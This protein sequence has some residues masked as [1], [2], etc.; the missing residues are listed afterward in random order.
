LVGSDGP[1]KYWSDLKAKLVDPK[2]VAQLYAQI[3]QL[4]L[5][6]A[7]GKMR[8]TDVANMATVLR[9]IQSIQSKNAEPF[10]LWL[11]PKEATR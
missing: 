7:D 4:K 11:A 2:G 3:V 5:P 10:K 8:E 9:I 1:R 6:A